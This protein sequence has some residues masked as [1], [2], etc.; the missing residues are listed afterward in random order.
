M[1][2]WAA[3]LPLVSHIPLKRAAG[4]FK[5]LAGPRIRAA[6][7]FNFREA[8]AANPALKEFEKAAG[9]SL[10]SRKG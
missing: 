7:I 2:F 6:A 10:V 1:K 4:V 9:H 5:A 8:K 3:A